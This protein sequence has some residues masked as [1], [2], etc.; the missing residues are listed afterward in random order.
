MRKW[1]WESQVAPGYDTIIVTFSPF[2]I[3]SHVPLFVLP[4]E[5]LLSYCDIMQNECVTFPAFK[6]LW[7]FTPLPHVFLGHL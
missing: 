4:Q 2:S 6:M 5:V 3:A 1:W 7:M